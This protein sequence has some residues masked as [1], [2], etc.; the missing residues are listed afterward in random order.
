MGTL[1][2]GCPSPQQWHRL[3]CV[4]LFCLLEMC[5]ITCVQKECQ[6]LFIVSSKDYGTV[7]CNSC[8][9]ERAYKAYRL[10]TS[11]ASLR[12]TFDLYSDMTF[13]DWVQRQMLVEGYLMHIGGTDYIM[14]KCWPEL[15]M[16]K[17]FSYQS[18]ILLSSLKFPALP[19]VPY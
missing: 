17:F 10:S 15:K 6:K 19:W 16:E 14:V 5:G 8:T 1:T 11:I 3:L 4:T 7:W 9:S 18:T 13:N 2:M 12:S